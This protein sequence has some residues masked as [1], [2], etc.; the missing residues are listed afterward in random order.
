MDAKHNNTKKGSSGKLVKLV[1]NTTSRASNLEIFI[2]VWESQNLHL[3]MLPGD[4]EVVDHFV[5]KQ[6]FT[7][8][9]VSL[10]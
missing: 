3:N 2:Q 1:Q 7:P 8:K 4:S 10:A 9:Y 6:D 5:G